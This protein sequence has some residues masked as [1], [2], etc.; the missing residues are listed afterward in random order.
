MFWAVM[1]AAV[2]GFPAAGAAEPAPPPHRVLKHRFGVRALAF[3][4]DGKILAAVQDGGVVQVWD[5]PTGKTVGTFAE[6]DEVV[7][8][9]AFSPDGK[10]LAT[11][12]YDGTRR[13]DGREREHIWLRD[14]ATWTRADAPLR[15][16]TDTSRILAFSPDG[17][18]L[19]SLSD[20]PSIR[21]W[22][23]GARK[24]VAYL[25][26]DIQAGGPLSFSPDGKTLAT[27]GSKGTVQLRDGETGLHVFTL[28]G[29]T[30]QFRFRI[31]CLVFSPDGKTLAAFGMWDAEVQMW[32]LAT[33]KRTVALKIALKRD[34]RFLISAAFSPDG[35]TLATGGYDGTVR[36]WEM[37]SGTQT[38]ALEGHVRGVAAVVFS[39]DGRTLAAA[40][41]DSAGTIKLWDLGR[42]K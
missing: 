1:C 39:P 2:L 35:K 11:A 18:T 12:G 3:S 24:S 38:A 14:V 16:H 6:F 10:T 36:L 22:D 29:D 31:D 41:S 33:R 30:R 23:L 5:V 27:A 20:D 21:V 28:P 15:G 42:D 13:S 34:D 7:Y 19:A 25:P 32:D 17:K 8:A 40:D 9:L 37:V 26:A 4:P